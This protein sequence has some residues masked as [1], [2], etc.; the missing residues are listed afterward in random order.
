MIKTPSRPIL[1]IGDAHGDYHSFAAVLIDAGL[2][3]PGL[4]WRGGRTILVQMGD[5]LDRGQEPLQIDSLLDLLQKQARAS[6][7]DII[8]LVGNHELEIL[9]KNYFITSLPRADIE[10]FRS[11][12]I[13]GISGGLWQAAYSGRGYL[14]T[15]A[16]VC[17]SLF[18]HLQAEISLPKLTVQKLAAQINKVFKEAV[19]TDNY[20]H[21]IFNVSRLRGGN[22]AFGGIF[23]EDITALMRHNLLCPFGQVVGHTQ[24]PAIAASSGNKII[25]IDVGMQNVFEG[26]FEYLKVN[27]RKNIK[28]YKVGK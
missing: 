28:I 6:G 10:K 17:D 24:V 13:A 16:G 11:K 23:W 3:D 8:R 4:N 1:A 14:F 9:R 2:M 20:Q 21:T 25:A 26:K 27:G 5:I 12:L 22:E 15:H 18:K 19:A 7:G